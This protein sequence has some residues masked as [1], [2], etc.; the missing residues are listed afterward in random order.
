MP[1]SDDLLSDP[2]LSSCRDPGKG[3]YWYVDLNEEFSTPRHRSRKRQEETGRRGRGLSLSSNVSE[4]DDLHHS[5]SEP[6][7]VNNKPSAGWMNRDGEVLPQDALQPV[8]VAAKL[9][10]TR[11][12]SL[13]DFTFSN[14]RN[15]GKEEEGK[16]QQ[17]QQASHQTVEG[18]LAPLPLSIPGFSSAPPMHSMYQ[19]V[20]A[21]QPSD[22]SLASLSRSQ[23]GAQ[24]EQ[25]QQQQ[26]DDIPSFNH[27]IQQALQVSNV[28]KASQY[29]KLGDFDG[30]Y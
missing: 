3:S 1:S 29:Y 6:H 13:S 11:P 22:F 4:D 30:I 20:S 8:P 16:Q 5:Q 23:F 19:R 15:D 2:S 14:D 27:F 9:A 21:S 24:A 26:R 12:R 17:P 18:H 28:D 25:Q 7:F 10:K